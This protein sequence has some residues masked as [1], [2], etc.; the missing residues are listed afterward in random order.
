M[1]GEQIPVKNVNSGDETTMPA[2]ALDAWAERGWEPIDED[3][4][5]KYGVTP[6][7]EAITSVVHDASG[8]PVPQPPPAPPG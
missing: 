2:E 7:T 4:R 8:E 1:A 5:T 6:P 3:W